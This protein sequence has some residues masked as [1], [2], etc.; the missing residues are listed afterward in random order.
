M[1]SHLLHEPD[2]SLLDDELQTHGRNT[3]WLQVVLT[4]TSEVVPLVEQIANE[5]AE[6]GFADKDIFAMR[7]ALEEAMVNGIRH[8]NKNDP[9]RRLRV[10]YQVGSE[11]VLAEV[12]DEGEGFDPHGVPDPT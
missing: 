2:V 4:C 11:Q 3:R 1:P 10:T 8:G 12:A 9:T 6:A 7:L 5:M